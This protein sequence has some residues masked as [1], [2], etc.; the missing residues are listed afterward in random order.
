MKTEPERVY[1]LIVYITDGRSQSRLY[2]V[3][4]FIISIY[5]TIDLAEL[6]KSAKIRLT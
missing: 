5:R 2:N 4:R 3:N 6:A 1:L